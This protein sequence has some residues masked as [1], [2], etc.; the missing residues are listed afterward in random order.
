MESSVRISELLFYIYFLLLFTT[1]V[2]GLVE[3]NIVYSIILVVALMCFAMSYLI[4]PDST[5]IHAADI[6]LLGVAMIAYVMS[7]EKGMILFFSMM[8]GARYVSIERLFKIVLLIAG[9]GYAI[10]IFLG[11]FGLIPE[12]EN[13]ILLTPVGNI[14]RRS[15][16]SL[17]VS[18]VMMPYLVFMMMVAYLL[19]NADR[20]VMLKA[21]G[22]MLCGMLYLFS[23]C[24]AKTALLA[25]ILFLL[26]NYCLQYKCRYNMGTKI[27]IYGIYSICSIIGLAAPALFDAT[28][29][30]SFSDMAERY[31]YLQSWFHRLY[32]GKYYILNNNVSLM[33][34]RLY[35]PNPDSIVYTL[36]HQSQLYLLLQYGLVMFLIVNFLHYITLNYYIKKRE[37]TVLAMI[38]I[39]AFIGMAEPMLFNLSYKNISFLFIGIAYTEAIRNMS[40]QSET[41]VKLTP[42][43]DS[44]ITIRFPK[45][46]L[47]LHS[48]KALSMK[49]KKS[50]LRSS[51][52]GSIA[53][54]VIVFIGANNN[55]RNGSL[56]PIDYGRLIVS[57]FMWGII[58]IGIIH[59]LLLC[60]NKGKED[61][62]IAQGSK[63][64]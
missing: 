27:A 54:I 31:S 26:L 17:N 41:K 51:L 23:Y 35:D 6:L 46:M 52:I 64:N 47:S 32:I 18:V 49:E 21:S 10:M 2:L 14:T 24:F 53:V 16:C 61:R 8:I 43:K 22:L 7:G 57:A 19:K 15:I 40:R 60:I 39:Y 50:I 34:K 3:G 48:I 5:S 56:L 11:A 29:I 44:E 62:G 37:G 33:G 12:A 25:G 20:L 4:V 58:I 1:R 63:K 28:G 30:N 59:S 38:L 9:L 45:I 42:L 36:I 13:I 55:L